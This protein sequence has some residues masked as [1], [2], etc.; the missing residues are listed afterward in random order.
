MLFSCFVFCFFAIIG[1]T[2]IICYL[3]LLLLHYYVFVFCFY[4]KKCTYI[5]ATVVCWIAREREKKSITGRCRDQYACTIL[6][7]LRLPFNPYYIIFFAFFGL[8]FFFSSLNPSPFFRS[9][10]SLL[11]LFLKV[12]HKRKYVIS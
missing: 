1:T 11:F 7:P 3:L 9:F 12:S 8:F 6:L 2:E 10:F 4:I 5:N